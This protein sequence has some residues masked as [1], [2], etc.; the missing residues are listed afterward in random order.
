[1]Q[2]YFRV[3]PPSVHQM[4][5]TL[6]RRGSSGDD[7][8]PRAASN[9][10]LIPNNCPSYFDRS[11]TGQIKPLCS[12]AGPRQHGRQ[13][14]ARVTERPFAGRHSRHDPA[15]PMLQRNLLFTGI[16]RGK[17]LV[18]LVGQNK[19]VAIALRKAWPFRPPP[20]AA[21][22][23]TGAAPSEACSTMRCMAD[24]R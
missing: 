20:P 1:M 7:Q 18:V 8:G 4:V 14:R 12:G 21:L 16:T 13:P 11:A 19:A 15:L 6:E 5:L 9:C 17:R 3:S 23:L 10:L 22:G 24:C 2:Q